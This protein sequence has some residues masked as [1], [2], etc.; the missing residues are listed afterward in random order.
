V[1]AKRYLAARDT[2]ADVRAWASADFDKHPDLKSALVSGGYEDLLADLKARERQAALDD[3]KNRAAGMARDVAGQVAA[4]AEEVAGAVSQTATE[5]A[6]QVAQKAEEVAAQV[7]EKIDETLAGNSPQPSRRSALPPSAAARKS[8]GRP[9]ARQRA[10]S[11]AW[12][13]HGLSVPNRMRSAGWARIIAR[14]SGRGISC[15]QYDVSMKIG[16][17]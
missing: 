2:F 6:G 8:S 16:W 12:S 13:L 11:A 17:P 7:S 5:V 9:R 4:K 15:R 1:V 10:S 14:A 3:L